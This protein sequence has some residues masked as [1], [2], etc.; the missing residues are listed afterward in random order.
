[1]TSLALESQIARAEGL[2]VTELDGEVVLMSIDR[3]FY[4]GMEATARRIWELLE[5]PKSVAALCE[6]LRNEF[7]VDP[8]VCEQEVLGFLRQLQ[9]EE[10]I[11]VA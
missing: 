2:L 5:T 11:V 4:Y 1:M 3:G 9:A 6:Q 7:D 8:S 10:L